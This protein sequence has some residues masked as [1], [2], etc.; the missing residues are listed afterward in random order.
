MTIKYLCGII[1]PEQEYQNYLCQELTNDQ[2]NEINFILNILKE[3]ELKIIN[4][5]KG[6]LIGFEVDYHHNKNLKKINKDIM[7]EICKILNP[8]WVKNITGVF[9]RT[10]PLEIKRTILV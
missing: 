5:P 4:L 3:K 8:E 10:N 9:T 6:I 2:E 1:I 7:I